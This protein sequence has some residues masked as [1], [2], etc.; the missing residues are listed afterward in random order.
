VASNADALYLLGAGGE[1]WRWSNGELADSGL[2]IENASSLAAISDVLYILERDERRLLEIDAQTGRTQ[3][4]ELPIN[5]DD[6]QTDRSGQLYLISKKRGLVLAWDAEMGVRVVAGGGLGDGGRSADAKFS[7]PFGV[8]GDRTGRTYIAD[9]SNNRIRV[10]EDGL[11]RSVVGSGRYGYG[12]DAGPAISASLSAPTAVVGTE[13]GRLFVADTFNHRIRVVSPSGWIW[14]FAGTGRPDW[15]G[16]GARATLHTPTGMC[17][18]SDGSLYIAEQGNHVVRRIRPDATINTIAG[19]GREGFSGDGGPATQASLSSPSAL[20]FLPDGTL[21]I[22]DQGNH[23]IRGVGRDGQ[24][25]SF[26][27]GGSAGY[28]GDGGGRILS[29]PEQTNRNCD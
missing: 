5:V 24:I 26:T 22:A 14:T 12:G 10:I 8:W 7:N 21:L 13:D 28:D 2:A 9:T 25:R 29:A 1:V 23:R 15:T 20:A 19:T 4:H 3:P 27:G 17:V 6:I 16:D 11:I 18:G